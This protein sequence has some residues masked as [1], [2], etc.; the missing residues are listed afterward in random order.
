M[1]GGGQK[2]KKKKVLRLARH[3]KFV[4]QP[5]SVAQLQARDNRES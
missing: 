4:F 1:P 3:L 2:K 5:C